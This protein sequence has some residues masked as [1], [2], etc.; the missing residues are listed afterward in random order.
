MLWMIWFCSIQVGVSWSV[1]AVAWWLRYR[2]NLQL[3]AGWR[4]SQ[5]DLKGSKA[6]HEAIWLKKGYFGDLTVDELNMAERQLNST[7]CSVAGLFSCF[8]NFIASWWLGSQWCDEENIT[9]FYGHDNSPPSQP[10]RP[11]SYCG[12][13]RVLSKFFTFFFIIRRDVSRFPSYW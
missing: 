10:G 3:K 8:G 12:S 7:T 9:L 6:I 5:N 13:V 2:T 1:Q 11:Y 4:K